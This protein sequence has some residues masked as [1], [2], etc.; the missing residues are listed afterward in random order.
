MAKK[1]IGKVISWIAIDLGL[2]VIVLVLYK[3]ISG[4]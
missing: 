3:V 1:T 2:L 4:F